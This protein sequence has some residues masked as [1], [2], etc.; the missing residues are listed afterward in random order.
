MRQLAALR[1]LDVPY[2]L[3]N[4]S[5]PLKLDG[6]IVSR[7]PDQS[8]ILRTNQGDI[9]IRD[10]G[11]PKLQPGD[12]ISVELG[13][14]N[15]PR[16]AALR[17]Y[18]PVASSPP[19][20]TPHLPPQAPAVPG[21]ATQGPQASSPKPAASYPAQG[22]VL[23][24][25]GESI[26]IP[27]PSAPLPLNQSLRLTPFSAGAIPALIPGAQLPTST[28]TLP[29]LQAAFSGGVL[30]GGMQ[31][32]PSGALPAPPLIIA[33][34][35]LQMPA[36]QG[37]PLA[38]RGQMG[39]PSATMPALPVMPTGA[40]NLT[41][42]LPTPV[43]LPQAAMDMKVLVPAGMNNPLGDN[44]GNTVP[45]MFANNTSPASQLAQVIGFTNR[46]QPILQ[47][48]RN[49]LSMAAQSTG[50]QNAFILHF[51]A[52]Q[53]TIGQVLQLSIPTGQGLSPDAMQ[54]ASTLKNAAW[55]LP[56]AWDDLSQLLLNAPSA[57]AQ[58]LENQLPKAGGP[59]AQLTGPAAL[60]LSLMQGGAGMD[61]L[62]GDDMALAAL[63]A[64]A[65][66]GR[67]QQAASDMA[68]GNAQIVQ[69]ASGQ[70]WRVMPLPLMIAQ[71]QVDKIQLYVPAENDAEKRDRNARNRSGGAMRFVLAAQL[72][73][74]GHL[75][76]EGL[77]Q[78]DK[79]L[80]DV[81]VRS[82]HP[83]ST[84]ART[85]IGDIYRKALNRSDLTGEVF[86]QLKQTSWHEFTGIVT[87][88]DYSDVVA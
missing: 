56:G 17:G 43:L 16:S 44:L 29:L 27:R 1:I 58:M 63:T 40:G 84:E 7:S 68:Q 86:F 79:K 39:L 42:A 51:P 78:P 82:E 9:K 60:L 67:M 64:R 11:N 28:V 41:T 36:P 6:Q 38:G 21:P 49:H 65:S 19:A 5:G 12:R 75:Q 47:L 54:L 77:F 57:A 24:Q 30:T 35:V 33:G 31:A 20:S 53:L 10:A 73:R 66:G 25:A 88:R 26:D 3:R 4:L 81:Q 69:D 18:Q 76:L 13:A 14:G 32:T 74:M 45:L 83:F 23:P 37:F 55:W 8:V 87:G 34:D 52:S 61:F 71:A 85:H 48:L 80:L 70:N 62:L 15:P 22:V 2:T 59:T 72:S 46:Q 50:H